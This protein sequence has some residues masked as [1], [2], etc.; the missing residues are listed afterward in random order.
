MKYF[1]LPIDVER[2]GW[3][4]KLCERAE[5]MENMKQ[6]RIDAGLTQADVALKCGV[7]LTS[8]RLWEHGVQKPTDENL[9]KLKAVLGTD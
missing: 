1:K 5:V 9:A 4:K 7:S 8:Y 2:Y 3:F 6:Y